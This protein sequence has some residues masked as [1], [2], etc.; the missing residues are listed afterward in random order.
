[1]FG[2]LGKSE[3]PTPKPEAEVFDIGTKKKVDA[4]R[5]YETL[6][7]ELGLPE[8]VEPG[9]IA[10]KAIKESAQYKM[11]QQ[12]VKSVLDEDYKPPKTTTLEEDDLEKG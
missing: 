3:K 11:N 4:R 1:M 6:K 7:K 9:S 5:Y 8:G 10:D 12:G 2:P